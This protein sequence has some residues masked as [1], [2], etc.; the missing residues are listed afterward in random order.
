MCSSSNTIVPPRGVTCAKP[1][2]STEPTRHTLAGKALLMCACST[3]GMFAIGF[4][5]FLGRSK[6]TRSGDLI[7]CRSNVAC[8]DPAQIAYLALV[9]GAAA[10]HRAAVVPDD[11]IA[12]A[13]FVTI[14]KRGLGG[15]LDQ[16]AQQQAAVG[17]GPAD[18]FRGVRGEVE[19]LALRTGVD[20][21][22]P[23]W[24]GWQQILLAEQ[25]LG[26]TELGARPCDVMQGDQILDLGLGGGG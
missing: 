23:L 15:V 1:L 16:V 8:R 2:G 22:Q 25:Q 20:S 10:V 18:D 26:E 6:L 21:H 11:Q 4:S 24:H 17:H 19:R 5:L 13:P 7:E 3:F 12:L 9:E 14:D